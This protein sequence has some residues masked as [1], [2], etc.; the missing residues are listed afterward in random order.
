MTPFGVFSVI[1]GRIS[2]SVPSSTISAQ[3]IDISRRRS[4]APNFDMPFV[5]IVLGLHHTHFWGDRIP[6]LQRGR[7]T[8]AE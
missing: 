2:A 6:S 8:H 1:I 5:L 7:S 4:Q 3:L